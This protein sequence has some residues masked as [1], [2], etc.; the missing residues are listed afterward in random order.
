MGFYEVV[1]G[2]IET[3]QKKE[4]RLPSSVLAPSSVLVPSS[5]ARSP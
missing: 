2:P 4:L 3:C 5:T 1:Y